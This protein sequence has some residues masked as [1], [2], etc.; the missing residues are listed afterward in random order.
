MSTNGVQSRLA[1]KTP[2]AAFF[3]VLQEEFNFSQRV[4][5]KVLATARE[6]LLVSSQFVGAYPC[7]R[8]DGQAGARPAPTPD[9]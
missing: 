2:E 5:A 3:H 8:P 1:L 9:Y 7:G 6:M 4:S